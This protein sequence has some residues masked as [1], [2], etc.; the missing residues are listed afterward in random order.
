MAPKE[1]LAFPGRMGLT[2][3]LDRS[4]LKENLESESE[5][6]SGPEVTPGSK[7]SLDRK[8]NVEKSVH[9]V[10]PVRSDHGV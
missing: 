10:F 3:F 2:A 6:M 8:A 9:E 1:T 4:D 5:E 7:V